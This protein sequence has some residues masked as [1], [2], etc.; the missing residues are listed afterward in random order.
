V[1]RDGLRLACGPQD[2]IF[3]AFGGMLDLRF[4]VD[5]GITRTPLPL[6]PEL[7]TAIDAGMLLID[8]GRRRVSGEVL[9]RVQAR[10]D[11]TAELVAAAGDVSRGFAEGSLAQVLA[12]MRRSAAAKLLRYPAGNGVVVALAER[13]AQRGAELVR[14]CGAG[15]GGHILVWAPP[16]RHEAIADGL[17][18]VVRKPA[19]AAPGVRLEA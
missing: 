10:A 14:M 16:D 5:G 18:C 9:S 11:T 13:L 12:G 15:E 17:G 4:D 6:D 1:E 19:L 7:F 2:P 8:T 3:A